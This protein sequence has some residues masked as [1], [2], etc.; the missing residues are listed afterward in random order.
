[1]AEGNPALLSNI[2]ETRVDEKPD[3]VGII[4]ENGGLYPDEL[5][6]YREMLSNSIKL[7]IGLRELG[8]EKGDKL[9]LV[10]RNHPEVLYSF[11]TSTLTG[12]VAVPI[13]PRSKGDKLTY[14]LTDSNSSG[15]I[16]TAD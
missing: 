14:Q 5:I 8:F 4:F 2:L 12:I 1:M 13:D 7:A 3:T 16:T 11:I 9:A 6:T 15:V 10:M